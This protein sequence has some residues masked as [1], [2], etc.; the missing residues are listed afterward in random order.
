MGIPTL[1]WCGVEGE[2]NVMIIDLLGATLEDLKRKCKGR[3]SIRTAFLVAEQL[4]TRV[5]YV[6]NKD[7]LHRD[8]KPENFMIGRGRNAK[9]IYV[10]DFGLARMYRDTISG[11]H[12]P[13]HTHKSLVGTA[14][15]VSINT[16]MGIEQGRRDDLES[17][18]YLL[19]YF[20]KGMLPWQRQKG[21]DSEESH[22]AILKKKL[23]TPIEELCDGLP[24]IHISR[25]NFAVGEFATYLNY[26]R[27]LKFQ[28]KPDYA[29]LRGIFRKA[30]M[31]FSSPTL[32]TNFDWELEAQV[33]FE[34]QALIG[35]RPLAA[36]RCS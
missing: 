15:Y 5:E 2:Y 26:C 25:N 18:G 13:F 3:F 34:S 10:I 27:T 11:F 29:Y 21:R 36:D 14:R 31:S 19:V 9:T 17:I 30:M 28:D 20:T 4:I 23:D 6:H 32:P 12:I 16:H 35:G 24:S 8:I 7:Y 33:L 22:A 1:H